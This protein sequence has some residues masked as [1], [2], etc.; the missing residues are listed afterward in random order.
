[1]KQLYVFIAMLFAGCYVSAQTYKYP[2]TKTVDA[3]DTYFGKELKDP[4]RWIEDIKND[5]VVKWFQDQAQFTN[6]V[7]NEIPGR[8]TLADE[9]KELSQ[10]KDANYRVEGK[11]GDTYYFSKRLPNDQTFKLYR[12]VGGNGEDDLL[13]D[14]E[15][16]EKDKTFNYSMDIND[17]GT[18]LLL[19]LYE[20]GKELGDVYIMDLRTKKILPDTLR[21]SSGEFLHSQPNLVLY[22]KSST[23]DIHD[24][25][26]MLDMQTMIHTLGNAVPDDEVIA[27]R[28]THPE[29][30]FERKDIGI[31][32]SFSNSPFI[33]LYKGDADA[34]L[35]LFYMSLSS[36]N[37]GN[38]KWKPLFDRSE[39]IQ[40]S[41]EAG[42]FIARQN[43]FFGI[44]TKGSDLGQ[45]VKWDLDNPHTVKPEVIL[46][47][48]N[49]WKIITMSEAKDY[50]IITL[51]KNNIESRNVKYNFL[52]G[53]LSEIS[54]PLHGTVVLLPLSPFSNE[55]LIFNTSWVEP[56]NVYAYDLLSDEFCKGPFYVNATYPDMENLKVEEIEVKSH[57]GT[58]VP[59]SLVY[60]ETK[61]KKD[62]SNIAIMTGYGSYGISILPA[63]SYSDIP[64]LNRGVVMA[65]AHVRGGGEKGKMWHLAGQK[66]NK[67]N[68]WKDFNACAE[69]LIKNNYTSPEH[70]ACTGAS[71]G[72]IL[73]GRAVTERPD[74]YKAAVPLV[75]AFNTV[76]SEFS[77]NGPGNIPEFGTMTDSI[78]SRALIEMDATLHVKPGVK[79]PAQLIT[80]GFNDPR[81]VSW[82]PAKYAATM[83]QS[84]EGENPILLYVDFDSGHF[85]GT[86]LKE[87]FKE[88]ADIDAF[89]LWQ[90][91]HPDFQV[92]NSDVN[93]KLTQTY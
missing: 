81:V 28:I 54:I 56:F 86:T 70:L 80:T 79:Y 19:N 89:I 34:N 15:N 32:V 44:T 71:A 63:F 91:G 24:P 43:M 78:E 84:N 52:T 62:G 17:I 8:Q 38:M 2:P 58:M 68:S 67:P 72:G 82:I 14:P 53:Q 37:A 29:L 65:Y 39:E 4:Y 13:F 93:V 50:L 47:G 45:I 30:Q 1:M 20:K 87:S 18:H 42:S 57:D 64:L 49:D 7:L 9:L 88:Q 76:R 16:F 48:E 5:E 73:I 90:C 59:L 40:N 92:E 26:V 55:G 69:Y 21:N 23:D 66:T 60:D 75:G 85:G 31:P 22:V 11:V 27:S 3:S 12:R 46:E 77:P 6:T 33:F 10:V 35:E 25:E 36:F 61:M 74:L 51:I 83:Q 41:F